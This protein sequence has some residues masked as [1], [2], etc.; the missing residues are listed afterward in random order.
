MRFVL[1]ALSALAIHAGDWSAPAE[2]RSDEDLVISYRAKVDGPNLIVKAMLKPGWHTFA[3][4]NKVRA[5]EKL[6]GKKALGE[7]RPT[8]FNVTGGLAVDGPW[9]Q[10]APVDFSKPELRIFTWGYEKEALFAAPVKRT[11]APAAKVAIRAQ[12]CTESICRDITTAVEVT[13]SAQ[14]PASIDVSSLTPVRVK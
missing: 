2:I 14:S 6:A 4:D 8:S 9:L 12:A 10:T 1:S 11:G 13:I 3:M 5:D 7:D